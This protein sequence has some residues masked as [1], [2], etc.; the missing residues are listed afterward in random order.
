MKAFKKRSVAVV[1]TLV[2]I[3][4]AVGIGLIRKPTQ[5]VNQGTTSSTALDTT[6]DTSYFDK[7]IYDQAEM[8]SPAAEQSIRLY[9]ANWDQ[10]YNSVVAIATV[11]TLSGKTMDDVALDQALNIGLGEGDAIVLLDK[12]SDRYVVYPGDE[13]AAIL[14][15]KAMGDLESRILSGNSWEEGVLSFYTGMNQL[16]LSNFGMGNLQTGQSSSYGGGSDWVTMAVVAVVLILIIATVADNYRYNDYRS[17]YYGM[18]NPPMVFHPI[19]FWHGPRYGWYRRRWAPPPPPPH[20]PRGPGGPGSFGGS[21]F[22]GSRSSSGFGGAG[23]RG[24]R[25]GGTFGGHTSRGGSPGSFGGSRGGGSFGGG[26]GGGSFG[27]RR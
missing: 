6:L 5:I 9:N 26:R 17:Q 4:A 27:G 11:N 23:N 22:G 8:L 15:D 13:F 7:F 3:A 1:L 18:P 20:D 25:G 12:E 10:R 16:Y 21:S 19:L 14:T 2:M 24:P